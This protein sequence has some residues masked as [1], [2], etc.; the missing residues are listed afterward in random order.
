MAVSNFRIEAPAVWVGWPGIVVVG[1]EL[2]SV[3][4]WVL[5][6]TLSDDDEVI[7]VVSVVMVV[8]LGYKVFW[9][10]VLI[11]LHNFKENSFWL[12]YQYLFEVEK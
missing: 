8:V 10:I 12:T 2:V 7:V 3:V 1:T 9:C 6:E 4:G 5:V 11:T